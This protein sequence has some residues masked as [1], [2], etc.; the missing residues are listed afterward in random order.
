M[1]L[2]SIYFLSISSNH[3]TGYKQIVCSNSFT[4]S[5][6]Y[7]GVDISAIQEYAK[8]YDDIEHLRA[9]IRLVVTKECLFYHDKFVLW[10]HG[11]DAMSEVQGLVDFKSYLS[12]VIF[13]S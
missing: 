5:F 3:L 7:F 1:S 13:A 11:F 2:K 8:T 12:L 4:N 6:R 10:W 9:E